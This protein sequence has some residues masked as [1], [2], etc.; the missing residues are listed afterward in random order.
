MKLRHATD[1]HILEAA[2]IAKVTGTVERGRESFLVSGDG[3]SVR[4]YYD[5]ANTRV[6]HNGFEV[7]NYCY[8]I[9]AYLVSL[10]YELNK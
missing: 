5:G 4:I 9:Y 3:R 7:I 8:E 2:A 6:I 10:G 1:E